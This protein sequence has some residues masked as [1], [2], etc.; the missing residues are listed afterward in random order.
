L[1]RGESLQIDLALRTLTFFLEKLEEEKSIKQ[2]NQF[3]PKILPSLF[4]SFT[5]DELDA[6]GRSQVLNVLYLCLRTVSWADGLDMDLVESCLG[7][8]FNSWMALFL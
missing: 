3:V 6:H 8:S 5:N 4:S 1:I 7:E 2:F